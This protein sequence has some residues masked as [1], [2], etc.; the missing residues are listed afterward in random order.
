MVSL[1]HR[2]WYPVTVLALVLASSPSI[3]SLTLNKR[4]ITAHI[5]FTATL[6]T[7]DEYIPFHDNNPE[8][9]GSDETFWHGLSSVKSNHVTHGPSV[10]TTDTPD[11]A[12]TVMSQSNKLFP[13]TPKPL[14][15]MD[16]TFR[17]KSDMKHGFT[18]TDACLRG[19]CGDQTIEFTSIIETDNRGFDDMERSI[20]TMVVEKRFGIGPD[21]VEI[22]SVSSIDGASRSTPRAPEI[23]TRIT[24]PQSSV[25]GSI[26]TLEVGEFSVEIMGKTVSVSVENVRIIPQIH[27]V[28]ED[29]WEMLDLGAFAHAFSA[30]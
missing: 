27:E 23:L 4:D 9:T 19:G 1:Q 24:V 15:K 12:K 17:K 10:M 22:V 8:S 16:N 29:E 20:Y 2:V 14:V 6:I 5:P 21:N 3:N 7:L 25:K 26:E 13:P 30:W 28:K 11:R 18:N